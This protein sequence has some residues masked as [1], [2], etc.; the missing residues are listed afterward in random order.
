LP[1][2]AVAVVAALFSLW[3]VV[4]AEEAVVLFC[5]VLLLPKQPA[6]SQQKTVL[7]SCAY[8]FYVVK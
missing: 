3:A 4:V 1:K 2:L 8:F 5:L 6:Y 7:C